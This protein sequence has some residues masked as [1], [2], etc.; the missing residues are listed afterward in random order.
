MIRSTNSHL[1]FLLDK[2]DVIRSGNEKWTVATVVEIKVEG[3]K[4]KVKFHFLK[5]QEKNDEWLEVDSP[6][7]AELYTKTPRPIKKASTKGKESR[8]KPKATKKAALVETKKANQINLEI[9]TTVEDDE[10]QIAGTSSTS[11]GQENSKEE[12]ESFS[13]KAVK[14]LTQPNTITD[15]SSHDDPPPNGAKQIAKVKS[16]KDTLNQSIPRKS[17]PQIR[18]KEIVY[19]EE[20]SS[21]SKGSGA[22][23]SPNS[24]S[25]M[26]IPRKVR[27]NESGSLIQPQSMPINTS[28]AVSLGSRPFNSSL[29]KKDGNIGYTP[30]LSRKDTNGKYPNGQLMTAQDG[31]SRHDATQ[32]DGVRRFSSSGSKDSPS[33]RLKAYH[34]S[35][36]SDYYRINASQKN[37]AYHSPRDK[38]RAFDKPTHKNQFH[39]SGG[40]SHNN[41]NVPYHYDD[42]RV[43]GQNYQKSDSQQHSSSYRKNSTYNEDSYENARPR[44]RDIPKTNDTYEG[45][46]PSRKSM[47]QNARY[48]D[49]RPSPRYGDE[50]YGRDY[51]SRP[52]HSDGR[53]RLRES[54]YDYQRDRRREDSRSWRKDERDYEIPHRMPTSDDRDYNQVSKKYY[55]DEEHRGSR[56]GY[57][58]EMPRDE[59]Y[60][61]HDGGYRDRR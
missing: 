4:K 17:S 60:S 55:R 20:A 9:D 49:E 19:T 23:S 11:N 1:S 15:E 54:Q 28:Q 14:S 57:R 42:R 33:N 13:D 38:K 45:S 27:S 50:S 51:Y 30:L 10:R 25:T 53:E 6:R 7:I 35:N 56:D 8:K 3:G 31:D 29:H 26:R 40:R 48:D 22:S 52:S 2:F 44:W 58:R 32:E 21:P 36:D 39:Q 61:R 5:N 24:K 34:R 46:S 41:S 16:D 37:G 59:R 12:N 18:R 43:Q 47:L